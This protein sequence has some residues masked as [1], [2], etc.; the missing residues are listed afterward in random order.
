MWVSLFICFF[1]CILY[2]LCALS[3]SFFLSFLPSHTSPQAK[4]FTE[5]PP[6]IVDFI[7]LNM[8]AASSVHLEQLKEGVIGVEDKIEG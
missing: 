5:T 3:F 2:F 6:Q 7:I 1:L 4:L 8:A